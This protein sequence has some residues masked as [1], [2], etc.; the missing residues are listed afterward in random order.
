MSIP[1]VSIISSFKNGFLPTDYYLWHGDVFNYVS[2]LPPNITFDLVVTSPPYNI[3]KEYEKKTNLREYI[4]WQKK[5]IEKIIPHIKDTG[6]IC[7]QIGNYIENGAIWPLDIEIA[8]IFRDFGLQLRNRIIWHF[9]HGLH[10]QRRFSGRYEVVLWFTKSD[11]YTFNLRS[12]QS[13]GQIS[14]KE[15]LQ[16]SEDRPI[17]K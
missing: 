11:N 1:S 9:G 12:R 13:S 2:N 10:T 5:I 7:W 8:P 14:F 15:G 17:F 4:N 3:G 16:G 6:S